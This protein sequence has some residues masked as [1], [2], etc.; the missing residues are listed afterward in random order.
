M[1]VVFL[2]TSDR[3]LPILEALNNNF[4]LAFCVTRTDAKVGRKQEL[5]ETYVKTWCKANKI[6]FIEVENLKSLNLENVIEKINSCQAD[7]AVVADFSFMIPQKIISSFKHGM[8]NIHFSL[9]PTY[10]GASPVQSAIL[11]GDDKTGV[12]FYI[13][14]K[15]MDTGAILKQF[16]YNFTH[17]ETS[18]E[19]YET[20]FKL[21]GDALPMVINDYLSGNLQP[22]A[23]DE[24][25]A[26]YSYSPSHP[27]NTF[28]Y[29]IDAKIDWSKDIKHLEAAIRAYNP[30]PIAWTTLDDLCAYFKLPKK[31]GFDSELIVKIHKASIVED[32]LVIELVQPQNSKKM[33]GSDFLNGYIKQ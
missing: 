4:E 8:I 18:G 20:L 19:L 31:D 17:K 30:W 16:E 2:G 21:A 7:I 25:K 33:T 9:L 14:D 15:G 22:F 11:N 12:T 28:I 6:D 1:K 10:R 5:K 23:Q 29:K 24:N 27:K 32:K 3:S 13:M 26:T